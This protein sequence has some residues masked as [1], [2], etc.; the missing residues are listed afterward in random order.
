MWGWR[1]FWNLYVSIVDLQHAHWK[2][3]IIVEF[4]EFYRVYIY[5]SFIALLEWHSRK[6]PWLDYLTALHKTM[7]LVLSVDFWQTVLIPCKS[8]WILKRGI[9]KVN[10]FAGILDS[11]EALK[12]IFAL[13][14][15]FK[16]LVFLDRTGLL[17]ADCLF[18]HLYCIS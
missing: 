17:Q 7:I 6:I 12:R 2:L 15:A 3:W 16:W 14:W 18:G 8:S 9:F 1:Q 10:D 4:I 5:I 13:S 11:V